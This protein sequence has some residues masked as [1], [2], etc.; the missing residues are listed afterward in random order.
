V[1][2]PTSEG[3]IVPELLAVSILV[4]WYL[5]GRFE[6]L[7]KFIR[8]SYSRYPYHGVFAARTVFVSAPMWW[9]PVALFAFT[10]L[11]P[12]PAT[13]WGMVGLFVW[14]AIAL[15]LAHRAPPPFTPK[16]LLEEFRNGRTNVERPDRAWDRGCLWFGV[17]ASAV[18]AASGILLI[19]VFR[20]AD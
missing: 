5:S 4:S 2:S 13:A 7:R 20:A 1:I 18:A 12:R 8:D 14:V 19:V 15:P 11:F 16:W 3:F 9:I 6:G 17:A 10:L